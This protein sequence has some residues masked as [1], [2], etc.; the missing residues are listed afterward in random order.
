MGLDFFFAPV[1]ALTKT[2][3]RVPTHE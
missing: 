1:T 3:F 2:G